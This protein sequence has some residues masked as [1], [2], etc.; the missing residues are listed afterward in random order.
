MTSSATD[1]ASENAKASGAYGEAMT[2]EGVLSAARSRAA[3][4]VFLAVLVLG[5]VSDLASKHYAFRLIAPAPVELTAARARS[6][7]RMSDLIPPHEPLVVV[8][9]LLE[10]TLVLNPGAVFGTGPGGRWFFV[11]FTMAA[12]A[13]AGVAF[14]RCIGARD[15]WVQ[16]ALGLLVSG[17]L[18]NLY[19][20]LTYACVRDF[21]HPLPNAVYPFGISTPWSGRFVWPYV[22]NLADLWLLIGIG[23]VL[24]KFWRSAGQGGRGESQNS[25]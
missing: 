16:V 25:T 9:G 7:V 13:L 10:L 20:R 11:G 12:L 21:L 23:I 2:R 3:W 6:V 19:D 15:R 22:S 5:L 17:G 14:F 18:G 1:S 24:V 4:I 8:P